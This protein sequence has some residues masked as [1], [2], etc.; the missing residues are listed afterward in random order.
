MPIL[1]RQPPAETPGLVHDLSLSIACAISTRKSRRDIAERNAVVVK[2]RRWFRPVKKEACGELPTAS[3][4]VPLASN[5]EAES[6]PVPVAA[7][8]D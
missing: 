4:G 2:L 8:K 6:V 7:A 3:K 1:F 5:L